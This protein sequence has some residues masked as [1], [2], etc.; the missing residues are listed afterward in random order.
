MKCSGWVVIP[1]TRLLYDPHF[2]KNYL[3]ILCPRRFKNLLKVR[4]CYWIQKML[5]T[6]LLYLLVHL[7]NFGHQLPWVGVGHHTF[8][9]NFILLSW[10]VFP[11]CWFSITDREPSV[12]H[13]QWAPLHAT[14]GLQKSQASFHIYI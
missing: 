14:K 10:Q 3:V 8:S 5:M 1:Q 7:I 13:R 4:I 2:Y 6:N 12:Y 11:K 9:I